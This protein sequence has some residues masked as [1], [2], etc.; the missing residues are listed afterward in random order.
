MHANPL[1][2]IL[3]AW[4]VPGGGHLLV[5]QVRKGAVFLVVLVGMFAIGIA[6]EGQLFAFDTAEPLVF[7]GAAAQWAAGLPR[8]VTGLLG[9]GRGDVVAVTYE[10]GN[11]FLIVA[12]LL[13]M[14]V[15]LDAL[16]RA[17]GVKGR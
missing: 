16:D 5:G 13:N 1:G 15:A 3:L 11:T 4:L 12:G 9:G 2:T 6:F 8:L 14:L 7:L 10:Y 17:R